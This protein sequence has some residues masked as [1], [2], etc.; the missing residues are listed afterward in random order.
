[1]PESS[2]EE[3]REKIQRWLKPGLY[4]RES[5]ACVAE[6]AALAVDTSYSGF[7]DPR[8]A[9]LERLSLISFEQRFRGGRT[10]ECARPNCNVS[11]VVD[12]MKD[13][14][15]Q[16]GQCPA[17]DVCIK[18][19]WEEGRKDQ[20]VY[21]RLRYTNP[22]LAT[23]IRAKQTNDHKKIRE[24]GINFAGEQSAGTFCV[25]IACGFSCGLSVDQVAGSA[26]ECMKD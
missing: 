13:T 22:D 23:Q 15:E 25:R 20:E 24:S 26:G 4:D 3:M 14:V 19:L 6:L 18:E 8:S 21:L 5:P 9:A 2:P 11:V 16:T 12:E 7:E 1:M 10:A 17:Q